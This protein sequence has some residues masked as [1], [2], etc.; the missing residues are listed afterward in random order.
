MI[1]RLYT[2][3][4]GES[5]FEDIEPK[6]EEHS[7]SPRTP[8]QP[9]EGII[10]RQQPASYFMDFHVAPLRQY[11]VGLS[12]HAEVVVGNGEARTFGPGDVM[13]AEDLTGRGHTLRVVGN[14]LRVS[15]VIPL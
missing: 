6:Y 4:D 8:L 7:L 15:M 1:T 13:L 10:F 14:Q 5:H 2:G 11:I 3:E 9:V 12:G